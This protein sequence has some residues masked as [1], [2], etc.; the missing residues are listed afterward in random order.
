MKKKIAAALAFA[1]TLGVG[2]VLPACANQAEGDRCDTRGDDDC[3][4]GLICTKANLLN[5]AGNADRCC[6][7][8]R[9]EATTSVCALSSTPG[10][11][12]APPGDASS[13]DA[14]ASDGGSDAPEDAPADTNEASVTDAADDGG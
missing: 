4:S 11:D 14:A 8:N 7:Q 9:A 6:P 3:Q 10:S 2:L 12:A 1:V 13:G 5:G